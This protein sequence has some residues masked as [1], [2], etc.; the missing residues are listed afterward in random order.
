M[1]LRTF[2]DAPRPKFHDT[3]AILSLSVSL[4]LSLSMKAR[5]NRRFFFC[6]YTTTFTEFEEVYLE[7]LFESGW[8]MGYWLC[9]PSSVCKLEWIAISGLVCGGLLFWNKFFSTLYSVVFRIV[10]NISSNWPTCPIQ[11]DPSGFKWFRWQVVLGV[12]LGCI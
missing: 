1:N 9:S 12:D 8:P 3:I 5:K 7:F 10:Q 11:T 2:W 4:S 6:D